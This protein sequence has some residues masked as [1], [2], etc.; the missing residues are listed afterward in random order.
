MTPAGCV[1]LAERLGPDGELRFHP[2]MG[3]IDPDLAWAGLRRFEDA[4]LP[5]LEAR[6]LRD[7][8]RPCSVSRPPPPGP[9]ARPNH[10]GVMLPTDAKLISVDDHLLEHP[11]VWSDRLPERYRDAGPHVVE[12]GSGPWAGHEVWLMEGRAYPTMK[13]YAIAGQ[14]R[15]GEGGPIRFSEMLPGCYD[16]AARLADMDLD[17]VWAQLCF[18]TFARFAGT[19]FL[20]C[21]DRDLA[22]AVRAGLQR[23]RARRVVRG[24]PTG[25]RSRSSSC[26]CGT[27]P[28]AWPRCGGP[29][30]REPAPSAS[31]RTPRRSACRA[32]TAGRGIRSSPRSRR[33]GIPLCMHF[34]TSGRTTATSDDC[35]DS[36][37]YT[38]LACNSMGLAADLLLSGVFARFPGLRVALSEGGIGWMPYF[39]ERIDYT[40]EG[41]RKLEPA[42]DFGTAA[43]GDVRRPRLRLLHRR[44]GR[45]RAAPSHRPV[46]DH[47]GVGLPARRQRV[48]AQPGTARQ[49]GS[50]TC[51]TTRCG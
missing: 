20:D 5:E 2:L 49:P 16:P 26:R 34:G 38:L 37:R 24:P 4:V 21:E 39:L 13:H 23:L 44:R 33:P 18:P 6:G 48:A 27:W 43:V 8:R 25:A 36:V 45:P 29:R 11:T 30:R 41:H 9:S 35:P 40:W 12:A 42:T 15:E 22:V 3:G 46:P 19:R 32:G 7:A 28:S 47:V 1:E 50:S 17:G 51:P 31:R 14:D 10:G